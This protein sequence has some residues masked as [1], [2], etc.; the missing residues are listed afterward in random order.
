MATTGTAAK[1]AAKPAVTPRVA[2]VRRIVTGHDRSGRSI[3]ASDA[4]SPHVIAIQGIASLGVTDI[5][6]THS[7]PADPDLARDPCGQPIQLAPPPRGTLVRIVQFPPDKVWA[8]RA[9]PNSAFASLG[10]SGAAALAR[11]ASAA[12]HPMM[13]CTAT[14][15][16]AIILKGEIWALM[17]IGETKM[18]AG[19]VLIQN[20]TN[21]AWANRSNKPCTVAFVLIDSKPSKKRKKAAKA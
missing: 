13:H 18:K 17:D 1:P 16:Y 14:V 15:D 10:K 9:D 21:H 6:K 11:D 4:S 7:T 19:D 8:K 12:R 2:K 5:W 20:A 3:I